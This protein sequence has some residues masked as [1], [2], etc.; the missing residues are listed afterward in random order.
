MMGVGAA[1]AQAHF[2]PFVQPH[3]HLLTTA[4]GNVVS[5]SPDGCATGGVGVFQDFHYNVHVG[6]PGL[7]AFPTRATRCRSPIGCP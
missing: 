1:S 5:I 6:E 4:S 3:V 2:E 7:G